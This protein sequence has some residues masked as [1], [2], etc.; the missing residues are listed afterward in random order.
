M[1]SIRLFVKPSDLI[2]SIG[3]FLV[4]FLLVFLSRYTRLESENA[5]IPSGNILLL[6]DGGTFEHLIPQ[7][8]ELGFEFD[9]DNLLWASNVFGYKNYLPGRY[10]FNEPVSFRQFLSK[11]NRGLQDPMKVVIGSGLEVDRFVQRVSNQFR[12]NADELSLAMSDS[13]LLRDI[14]VQ[15]KALIGRMLPNTYEMYWTTTPEQFIKRMMQEFDRTVVMPYS[16]RADELKLTI[17][18]VTT[19]ASIIE[20][21]VRHVDEKPR[22]SGLYWNRLNRRMLLQADPTVAYAI[23][24]RRRLL[25]SDYRVDHPYNTYRVRGLPPGPINNPRLTSIQA[26]LFPEQHNYLFMVATPQG[27][28]AFTTNYNDHLRESRKW[29][30]WLREQRQIRE[31]LERENVASQETR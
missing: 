14:E 10:A 7:L 9:V 24:E 25:F 19:L 21:E 6:A 28:H 16:E 5:I 30:T 4:A 23:G 22:V 18:E 29:T 26:A 3:V 13:T 31:R 11:L 27:Y 15:S 1:I 12:F 20:W 17:D 2:L 8:T